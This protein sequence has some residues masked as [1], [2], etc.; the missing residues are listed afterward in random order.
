MR[1]RVPFRV[2][3]DSDIYSRLR[4]LCE[5][6]PLQFVNLKQTVNVIIDDFLKMKRM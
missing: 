3:I 4:K 5:K 2:V 1:R 6:Y